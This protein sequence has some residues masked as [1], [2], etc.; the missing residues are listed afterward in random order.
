MPIYTKTGDDGTTALFGGDRVKKSD[1]RI[2]AGGEIDELTSVL[3]WVSISLDS[4][5]QVLFTGIQKDLYHIMA[6]IAGSK[7][8]V[9]QLKK[10]TVYFEKEIDRMEKALPKLTRFILPG[11]TEAASRLHVARAVCRRAERA[12]VYVFNHDASPKESAEII[13]YLNR[14]SDLLFTLAR[15]YNK[16]REFLT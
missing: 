16:G 14:L 12:A 1:N 9:S 8:P 5:A 6:V 13:K 4:D 7:Q 2:C 15:W 3:G 10:Q 11:G